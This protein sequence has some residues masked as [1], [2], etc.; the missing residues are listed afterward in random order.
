[1]KRYKEF[2]EEMR[3]LRYKKPSWKNILNITKLKKQINKATG[4]NAFNRLTPSRIRQRLLQQLG[5]YGN[6]RMTTVRQ[7]SH[8]KIRTPFKVLPE[9]TDA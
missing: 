7:L 2:L 3:I 9:E 4:L 6:E 5:V 8:G 1:M